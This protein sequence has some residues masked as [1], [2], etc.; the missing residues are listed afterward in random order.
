M[1]I[2]CEPQCVGFEHVEVNTALIAAMRCAF[3]QEEILFL[4]EKEHLE[5]VS[6]MLKDQHVKIQSREIGIP[7][8]FLSNFRRL[9]RELLLCK[10]VFKIARNNGANKVLFISIT[11]STL[12]AIKVLLRFFTEIKCVAIP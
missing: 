9:P 11:S 6:G 7:P 2:I 10:S 3:P 1:I 8:R 12:I 4:A 5:R